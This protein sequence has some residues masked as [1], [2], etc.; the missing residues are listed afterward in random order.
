MTSS[1]PT[2]TLPSGSKIPLV[3]LG[4][5]KLSTHTASTVHTALSVGYR[6]LDGAA[7]YA[8]ERECG[9]GL[10]EAIKDG[11]VKREEVFVVSK[12]WNTDHAEEHVEAAC[13]RSLTD[14]GLQWFDLYL[15]H[16][17]LSLKY[18]ERLTHV[19]RIR[20]CSDHSSRVD[21]ALAPRMCCSLTPVDPA[22]RYPPGWS[23]DGTPTGTTITEPSPLHKT[24]AAM[25]RLVEK[26]LVNNI[27]V[28]NMNGGLVM[29]LMSYAKIKPSV[30]QVEHHP[31]VP[32]ALRR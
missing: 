30:L 9:A 32:C 19:F 17:P 18:G 15:I 28:C 8:N 23:H 7:D 2:A 21:R 4:L 22:V 29:D 5:W 12:L 16:F 24:W 25:E 6:L 26:G 31:W 20:R 3:G 1:V 10:A 11:T 13:R 27:G 14:W